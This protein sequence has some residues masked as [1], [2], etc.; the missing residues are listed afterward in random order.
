M[1]LVDADLEGTGRKLSHFKAPSSNLLEG[2]EKDHDTYQ[3]SLSWQSFEVR[4]L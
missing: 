4:T 1:I 3:N 2:S